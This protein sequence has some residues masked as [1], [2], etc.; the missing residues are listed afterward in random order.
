VAV[1]ESSTIFYA[2]F[3]K[4]ISLFQVDP[5]GMSVTLRTSDGMT[6]NVVFDQP[7]MVSGK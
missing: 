3:K 5:N 7:V 2:K 4:I 1:V 6:V